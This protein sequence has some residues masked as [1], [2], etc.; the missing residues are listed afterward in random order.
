MSGKGV[1]VTEEVRAEADPIEQTLVVE[2]RPTT[3]VT[4]FL[5]HQIAVDMARLALLARHDKA[6]RDQRVR[7][8]VL[9]FDDQRLTA[10]E[11]Y[12]DQIAQEPTTYARRLQE[13]I[14]GLD[15]V[16]AALEALRVDLAVPGRWG[17]LHWERAENLLGRRPHAI[18][19][20]RHSALCQAAMG[21]F[22]A[23]QPEDGA[24]LTEWERRAWAAEQLAAELAA[25][26]ERLKARRAE[27]DPEAVDQDRAEAGD[28]ALF[29]P[30]PAAVLFRK[31]EAALRRSL[32]RALKEFRELEAA[33]AATREAEAE[34][35]E[36]EA[37]AARAAEAAAVKARETV[38][39]SET[40]KTSESLGSFLPAP[41]AAAPAPPVR[42]SAG[43][44]RGV[45][46]PPEVPGTVGGGRFRSSLPPG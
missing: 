15:L 29:D 8:A 2:M 25:R 14:E 18:P 27:L 34:A 44:V 1:V 46:G 35:R 26:I 3:T 11:S 38:I 7:H 24:G 23:L 28:R 32:Y 30:S 6:C 22:R 45:S 42:P 5:V 37:A 4:R 16:I 21:D 41:A 36:A 39:T 10:P 33:A 31:Y 9:E 19:A 20:T 40:K 13:S 43:P 17:Y 12:L